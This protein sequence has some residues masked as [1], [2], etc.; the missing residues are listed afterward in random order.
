[1]KHRIR[2]WAIVGFLV[3]GSWGLYALAVP[4][5]PFTSAD[6]MTGLVRL[7]C[8]IALLSS[9]PIRLYWVLLANTA[10]YALVG[11]VVETLRQ[12]LRHAK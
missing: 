2:T 9:Y 5:P 12:R 10:T 8:P 3:A 7:T 1:M 6:P 4:P 11:L